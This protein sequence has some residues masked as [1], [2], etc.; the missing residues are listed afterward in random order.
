[1]NIKGED[2]NGNGEGGDRVSNDGNNRGDGEEV[3][4]ENWDQ[5]DKNEKEGADG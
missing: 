1:M 5:K 4:V 2:L 3:D